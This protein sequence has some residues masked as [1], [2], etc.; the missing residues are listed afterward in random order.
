MITSVPGAENGA[1]GVPCTGQVGWRSTE[2]LTV[3][4][5][6]VDVGPPPDPPPAGRVVVVA[7]D[8]PPDAVAAPELAPV[9]VV[10]EVAAVSTL[11]RALDSAVPPQPA[12]PRVAPTTAR[13]PTS[14]RTIPDR[15]P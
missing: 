4:P 9:V 15:I 7:P 3:G 14:L 10:A 2:R 6:A 5:D 8:F 1:C 11:I 12:A 13:S